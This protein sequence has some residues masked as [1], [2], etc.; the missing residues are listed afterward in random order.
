MNP[1]IEQAKQTLDRTSARLL[2]TF[3]A[4]PDDKLT[5][6]PSPSAK[7]PL[8]LVAHCSFANH[9]MSGIVSGAWTEEPDM[10]QIQAMSREHESKITSR[11]Q[12]I[13]DLQQSIAATKKA[14]DEVSDA[15]LGETGPM[16]MPIVAWVFMIPSHMEQHAAQIDYIETCYGDMVD[17]F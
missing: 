5:W 13:A 10:E 9:G 7:S 11:A 1:T 15:R 16:N 17:H 6:S 12:A 8:Q 14:F 2:N 3:A 4:V